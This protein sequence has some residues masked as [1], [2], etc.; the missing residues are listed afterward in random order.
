[1]RT[2]S[3]RRCCKVKFKSA[4]LKSAEFKSAKFKSAECKSAKLKSAEFTSAEHKSANMFVWS[5]RAGSNGE[6]LWKIAVSSHMAVLIS[7]Q[8]LIEGT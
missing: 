1:M 2:G 7:N 6:Q 5:C 4:E 3:K 8:L